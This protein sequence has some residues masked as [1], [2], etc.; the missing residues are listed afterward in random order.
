MWHAK[1]EIALN[2]LTIKETAMWLMPRSKL[3]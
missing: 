2:Q 1:A 3:A